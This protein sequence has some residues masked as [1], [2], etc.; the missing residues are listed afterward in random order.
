[1]LA[2]PAAQGSDA[3]II[4][5]AGPRSAQPLDL[6]ANFASVAKTVLREHKIV[7][8][9]RQVSSKAPDGSPFIAQNFA[10]DDAKKN[11]VLVSLTVANVGNRMAVFGF[12]TG[13]QEAFDKH[14]A[15]YNKMLSGSR[16]SGGAGAAADGRHNRPPAAAGS[17]NPAANPKAIFPD[18]R[19]VKASEQA[20]RKPGFVS[21]TIYGVD[22]KP[23]HMRGSRVT[24]FVWGITG[25]EDLIGV[26][27]P[28]GGERTSYNI[29]VD[30]RGHY[31]L[32]IA[33]GGYRIK[34]QALI[35]HRGTL[36]P[37]DL[38][39][40]DGEPSADYDLNSFRGIVKDFGLKLTGPRAGGA[41]ANGYNGFTVGV[42]DAS[43]IMHR[44]WTRYPAGT[45]LHV[46]LTPIAPLLDGSR[47]WPID[48]DLD[49][50]WMREHCDTDGCA[51]SGVP[52]ARYRVTAKYVQP[53]GRIVPA[54]VDIDT[55]GTRLAA[56]AVL[57]FKVEQD[58]FT[59]PSVVTPT[60]YVNDE[61]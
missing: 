10:A 17:A 9:S 35:P 45:H 11:R 22:G 12:L 4:I 30:Q 32:E 44:S 16:F 60:V 57:D 40:L 31:E 8:S 27:G 42:S 1:M 14:N 34:A 39:P 36:V 2:S 59:G 50:S 29:N 55:A 51:W 6:A 23:W 54:R 37:V 58:K 26:G 46:L 18:P 5:F 56:S 25:K 48:I 20:R 28:P 13:S 41:A 15:A 47:G 43:D 19:K 38:D 49:I 7:Q 52:Y 33:G 21:G 61:P 3:R 53:G 24:V